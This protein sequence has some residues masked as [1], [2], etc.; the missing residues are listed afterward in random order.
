MDERHRIL[1]MLQQGKVSVDEAARLLAAVDAGTA[2]PAPRLV[3]VRVV[4]GRGEAANLSVPVALATTI[5]GLLPERAKVVINDQPLDVRDL[6]EGLTSGA[7][8][9][10][11]VD[12]STDRGDRIEIWVE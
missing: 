8:S 6:V 12:V 7:V 4:T 9:G 5:L 11:L 3:R 2:R 10:K 1:E